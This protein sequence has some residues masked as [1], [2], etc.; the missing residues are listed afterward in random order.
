MLLARTHSLFTGRLILLGQEIA[1]KTKETRTK[2]KATKRHAKKK[3]NTA[4]LFNLDDKDDDDESE[5]E[6]DSLGSFFVHLIDN[7]Y[8]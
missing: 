7:D 4:E 3:S 2:N 1:R 5:V 6:L 8:Y